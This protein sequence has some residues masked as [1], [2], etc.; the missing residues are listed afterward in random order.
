MITDPHNVERL[1]SLLGLNRSDPQIDAFIG[2]FDPPPV[3]TADKEDD[4]DDE[5]V[6]FTSQ[7]FGLAFEQDVLHAFHLHSGDS[8]D[9]YARY[10]LPLPLG[11]TFEQCQ[12]DLLARLPPPDTQGGGRDGTFGYIPNWIRY[13]DAHGPSFHVEFASDTGRVRM[14]TVMLSEKKG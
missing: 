5:F 2:E 8:I 9:S 1:A 4:A 6:E 12:S 14:V 11:I 13:D 3:I 7:G 10:H